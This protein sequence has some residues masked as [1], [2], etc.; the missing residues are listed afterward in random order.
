MKIY[1]GFRSRN[2]RHYQVFKNLPCFFLNSLF[3]YMWPVQKLKVHPRRCEWGKKE[4][5]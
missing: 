2:L 3:D 1:S 5:N 4:K